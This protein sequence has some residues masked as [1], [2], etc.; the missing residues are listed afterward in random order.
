MR[1]NVYYLIIEPE[2]PRLDI[3]SER[4]EGTV[5]DLRMT[6]ELYATVRHLVRADNRFL[7]DLYGLGYDRST[8]CAICD[9]MAFAISVSC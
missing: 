9:S 2:V 8:L 5:A 6:D 1:E 3:S 7:A 4:E